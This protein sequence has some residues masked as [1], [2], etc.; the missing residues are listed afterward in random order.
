MSCFST[1]ETFLFVLAFQVALFIR[2]P[3]MI[4]ILILSLRGI[5]AIITLNISLVS[6]ARPLTFSLVGFL[7]GTK[8]RLVPIL[9]T[10]IT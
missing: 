8:L 9:S 7:L 3:W 6:I 1:V 10:D 4:L 5:G 2:L